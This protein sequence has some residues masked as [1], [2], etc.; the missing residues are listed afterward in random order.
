MKDNGKN[1]ISYIRSAMNELDK[2]DSSDNPLIVIQST[3][4]LGTTEKLRNK[5]IKFDFASNP[6]FLKEISAIKD[7]K[8]ANRIVFGAKYNDN[9][10]KLKSI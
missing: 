7:L 2:L 5:Y 10:E 8:S 9:F 3:V 1:D 4:V 6:E